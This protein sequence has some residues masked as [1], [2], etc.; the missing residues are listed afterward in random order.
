[1]LAAAVV[2]SEISSLVS[3]SIAEGVVVE[4]SAAVVFFVGGVV[5]GEAGTGR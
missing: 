3:T 4:L 5:F 2:H 1:M